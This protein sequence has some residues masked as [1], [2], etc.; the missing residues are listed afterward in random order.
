MFK[1]SF[2]TPYLEFANLHATLDRKQITSY[3]NEPHNRKVFEQDGNWGLVQRCLDALTARAI[4]KM[5][6]VFGT[7]ELEHLARLV[8]LTPRPTVVHVSTAQPPLS[9][10]H[11]SQGANQAQQSQSGLDIQDAPNLDGQQVETYLARVVEDMVSWNH[12][13][14]A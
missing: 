9:P 7:V 12:L 14:V 1:Q 5:E 10:A 13:A 8:G 6:K 4:L 3:V 2:S 11:E